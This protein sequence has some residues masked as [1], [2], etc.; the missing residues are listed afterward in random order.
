MRLQRSRGLALMWVLIA[1]L[2][3]SSA[4]A[5]DEDTAIYVGGNFGRAR[6]RYDTA[7]LD[8]QLEESA[9]AEG[10][11]LSI[12][13]RSMQ[14]MSDLWW[15]DAGYYFVPHVALEAA[16]VHLGEFKYQSAGTLGFHGIDKPVQ[17]FAEVSSHGPAVALAGRIPLTNSLELDLKAGDYVA[18]STLYDRIDVSTHEVTVVSSKSHSS[19]FAGAGL[20]YNLSPHCSVRADYVRFT[21][22]GDSNTTGKFSVDTASLGVRFTF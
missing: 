14:R 11:T 8:S 17:S 1:T 4:L 2:V 20:G 7:S 22:V 9:T 18:K 16:F 3:G 15:A 19:P 21:K 13:A 5:D 6:N 10:D 12:K